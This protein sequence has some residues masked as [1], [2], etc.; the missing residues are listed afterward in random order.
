MSRK[1]LARICSA[2]IRSLR[3]LD[4]VVGDLNVLL[5][6]F[7][8]GLATLDLTFVVGQRLIDRLPEAMQTGSVYEPAESPG[9]NIGR[10][11]FR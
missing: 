5:A 9:F 6:A 2:Q 7:A 3:R 1:P 8:I 11:G 4:R 10:A